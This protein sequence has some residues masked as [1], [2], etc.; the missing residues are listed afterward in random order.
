[1]ERRAEKLVTDSRPP[2]QFKSEEISTLQSQQ[3]WIEQLKLMNQD[4]WVHLLNRFQIMLREFIR[5]KLITAGFSGD[6]SACEDIQQQTWNTAIEKIH[7]F[8]WM[9]EIQLYCWLRNIARNHVRNLTQKKAPVHSFEAFEDDAKLDAF[10]NQHDLYEDSPESEQELLD[11]VTALDA[12][13]REL[14]ARDREIVMRRFVEQEKPAQLARE[15]NMDVLAIYKVIDRA[16]NTIE[17]NM[18]L[19]GFFRKAKR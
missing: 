15:Y 14:S 1:M 5:N 2:L 16:K 13:M 12:A 19:R 10:L 3:A 8:R 18:N 9:S 6:D 17:H 4:A 11:R 7:L